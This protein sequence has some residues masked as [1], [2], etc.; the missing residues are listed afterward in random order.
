MYTLPNSLPYVDLLPGPFILLFLI[1]LLPLTLFSL[2]ARPPGPASFPLSDELWRTTALLGSAVA[3]A[4]GV[5]MYPDS[6]GDLVSWVKD[7]RMRAGVMKVGI[8]GGNW[9]GWGQVWNQAQAG[10]GVG[11]GIGGK[12][13]MT[14]DMARRIA[15]SR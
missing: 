2:G 11:V 13:M 5:G 9:M 15:K 12:R 8:G 14:R 3:I 4:I 10:S 6:M 1:P 7:G